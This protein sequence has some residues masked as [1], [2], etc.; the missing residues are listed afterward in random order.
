[1]V[2]LFIEMENVGERKGCFNNFEFELRTNIQADMSRSSW[3]ADG[4][5][6]TSLLS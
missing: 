5:S 4:L 3:E 1:M 2:M 6:F